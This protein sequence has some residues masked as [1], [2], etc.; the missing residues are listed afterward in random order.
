[1]THGF[2]AKLWLWAGVLAFCGAASGLPVRGAEPGAEHPKAKLTVREG[3]SALL[4]GKDFEFHLDLDAPFA[5]GN[6]TWRHS[7]E[8]R[9]LSSG[10]LEIRRGEPATLRLAVPEVKPGI[11]LRTRLDL[12]VAAQGG[13]LPDA[14]A[15][16]SK[17]LWILD[18]NPFT[19]RRSWLESLELSLYDPAGATAKKLDTLKIPF[20]RVGS[21]GGAGENRRRDRRRLARDWS[22]T[23]A[24]ARPKRCSTWPSE[25]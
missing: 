4:A 21:L 12:T 18:P 13:E 25:A 23:K 1:M 10:E 9:T 6:V 2:A 7:M 22:W 11:A 5:A 15:T 3:T 19:L 16:I 8:D 24:A 20:R 17:T 14:G